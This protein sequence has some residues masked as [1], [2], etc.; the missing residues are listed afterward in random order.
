MFRRAT[1]ALTAIA[2]VVAIARTLAQGTGSAGQPYE[3][4]DSHF[5][6]TNY[7]QEGVDIR[8]FLKTMGTRVGRVALFGIPLQQMW[9]HNNT[10]DFAPT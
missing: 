9:D 1:L 4:T 6:L 2:I 7:A 3:L 10:G 8:D 5:H